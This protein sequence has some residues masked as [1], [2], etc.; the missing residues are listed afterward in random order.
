MRAGGARVGLGEVLAAQRAVAAVDAA[1]RGRGLLRAARGAVLHAR[2]AERVR[3]R[4]HGRLRRRRGARPARRARRAG[5]AGAAAGRGPARRRRGARGR[6]HARARRLE[7]GG[8]AAREGL[9]RPTPTPSARWRGG[10]WPGSRCAGRGGARGAPCR[11]SAAAT[12]TTCAR[13]SAPRCGHGGELLERRYREPGLAPAAAR[14]DL[15]RVGLDGALL[16]DAAAVHAGL[17]RRPRAGRGV[18]VRHAAHPRHARAA[19]ARLRP[20]AGPRRGRGQRLVG[21]HADR[22]GDRRAQPRARPPDRPRLDG[23]SCSPTAGTAAS[24]RSSRRR[25]RASRAPRTASSG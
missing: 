4:V 13:P 16:A 1:D 6:P 7:R 22:R 8:A 12:S 3:G 9:R 21:R 10:C 20:R 15:R 23:R 14:A 24:P 25:W 5:Q 11:P 2:R 18:R 17:R 19:R